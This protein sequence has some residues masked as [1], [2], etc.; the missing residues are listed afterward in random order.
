MTKQDY[1]EKVVSVYRKPTP[2]FCQLSGEKLTESNTSDGVHGFQI[3][4]VHPDMPGRSIAVEVCKKVYL[5]YY[6]A[7]FP[8]APAP[9]V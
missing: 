6:K 7:T 3:R 8:D 1:I 2:G 5:E 9:K 4:V